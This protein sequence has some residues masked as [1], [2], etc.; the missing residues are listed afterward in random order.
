MSVKKKSQEELFKEKLA[1][2]EEPFDIPE[3]PKGQKLE[4][5]IVQTWGDIN[6]LGLTGIEV[7]DGHGRQIEIKAEQIKASPCDINLLLGYGNDPRTV[8]KL[9]DGTYFTNDDFHAWLTPF[10][11]GEDH[12]ISIDLG[13]STQISLIRVWNYNK[14]RIHSHR[15]ARFVTA[16]LDERPIFQGEIKRA[17]GNTN[18][19]PQCC[20]VILFTQQMSILSAIDADDW[21]NSVPKREQAA[22]AEEEFEVDRPMTADG[23][24]PKT[25]FDERPKT[26]AIRRNAPDFSEQDDEP[27]MELEEFKVKPVQKKRDKLKTIKGRVIELNIT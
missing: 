23:D 26:K 2:F 13:Q 19:L 6:Y 18:D 16:T 27:N 21:V 4:F 22:P 7:F 24:K 12:S 20:E 17:P 10:T 11:Q 3:L 5:N 9:V 1:T 25:L 15:G 14:S 8:D